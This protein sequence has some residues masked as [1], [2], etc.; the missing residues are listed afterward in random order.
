[1]KSLTSFVETSKFIFRH[2][3]KKAI[4]EIS[5]SLYRMI[6]EKMV[7]GESQFVSHDTD[8]VIEG[9]PGSANSFVYKI[10]Q[11]K[12]NYAISIATHIHYPAQIYLAAEFKK[13][14]LL[15]IR[16]PRD[17]VVS[18]VA[19]QIIWGR[20][21]GKFLELDGGDVVRR[22]KSGVRYYSY[23]Y[24]RMLT[25]SEEDVFFASFDSVIEDLPKVLRAFND[26]Y[27]LDLN[28]SPLSKAEKSRDFEGSKYDSQIHSER[29]AVRKQ[30]I[31]Y[32]NEN[33]LSG[34]YDEI[35]NDIYNEIVS[36]Y[37]S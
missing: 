26:R 34:T 19:K 28:V 8:L 10:V 2:N 18:Y 22:L 15:L 33:I 23:Y 3:V 31:N 27:E 16:L 24:K 4:S 37:I 7:P 30:I 6:H 21:F 14:I 12:N 17:A 35:C 25:L 29:T 36:N 1:M 13:P 32:Y 9:F 11:L 20:R 5:P